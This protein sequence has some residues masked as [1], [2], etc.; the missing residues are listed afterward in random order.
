MFVVDVPQLLSIYER[1][2][3][4]DGLRVCLCESDS[5]HPSDK[6][7]SHKYVLVRLEEVLLGVEYRINSTVDH[8]LL[9]LDGP[10]YNG[11]REIERRVVI[12]GNS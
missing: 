3:H 11:R 4:L 9:D 1:L 7:G 2:A 10:L 12:R 5:L 8:F 6:G